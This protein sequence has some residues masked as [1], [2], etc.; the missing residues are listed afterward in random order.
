MSTGCHG[1]ISLL[2]YVNILKYLFSSFSEY[3][4]VECDITEVRRSLP[5]DYHR[6]ILDSLG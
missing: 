6:L 4:N 3:H 1:L 5:P 2:E